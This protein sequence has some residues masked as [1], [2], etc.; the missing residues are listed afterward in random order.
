MDRWKG[1][2]M[3]VWMDGGRDCWKGEWMDGWMEIVGG[4]NGWMDGWMNG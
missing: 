4:R 3:N 2:W 1:E